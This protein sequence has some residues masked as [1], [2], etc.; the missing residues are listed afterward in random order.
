[1]L[2]GLYIN[3]NNYNRWTRLMFIGTAY[4]KEECFNYYF[5]K[6]L[7]FLTSKLIL[8]VLLKIIV[9]SI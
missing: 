4:L 1:M 7:K 3:S 2:L 9:N 6:A 8:K 5:I